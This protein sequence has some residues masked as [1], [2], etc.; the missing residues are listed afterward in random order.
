MQGLNC[1]IVE[2]AFEIKKKLRSLFGV[3]IPVQKKE[4]PLLKRNKDGIF[5]I[6][7]TLLSKQLE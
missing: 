2:R 4:R 3:D 6:Q 5:F 7:N 1:R